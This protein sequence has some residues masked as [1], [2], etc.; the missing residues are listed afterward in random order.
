MFT[1]FGDDVEN[2]LNEIMLDNTRAHFDIIKGNYNKSIR[3]PLIE[4]YNDLTT[5][6]L[7]IDSNFCIDKRRC[8]SSVYNDFRFSKNKPIKEYMYIKYVLLSSN[9][10]NMLGYF[11]DFSITGVR[12]GL[13]LYKPTQKVLSELLEP[14]SCYFNNANEKYKLYMG[15]SQTFKKK[16]D[17]L[18]MSYY[19]LGKNPSLIICINHNETLE[20]HSSILLKN[21]ID[22]Y[23]DLSDIY[24]S[25]KDKIVN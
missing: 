6:V 1:G 24:F 25:L 17:K 3:N 18:N 14:L 21:V 16:A 19:D 23:Y 11:I 12:Y 22:L 9:K 13:Q 4:L 8:I 5:V 2:V 7:S 20:L 10:K 15:G